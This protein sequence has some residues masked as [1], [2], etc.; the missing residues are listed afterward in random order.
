MKKT[1]LILRILDTLTIV[2]FGVIAA[3]SYFNGAY[4]IGLLS[5]IVFTTWCA[6]SWLSEILKELKSI[7]KKLGDK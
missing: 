6:M 1:P 2:S 7:N 5:T 3:H 4:I